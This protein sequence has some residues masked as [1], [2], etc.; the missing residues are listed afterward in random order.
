MAVNRK[1]IEEKVIDIIAEQLSRE[2]D[3]IKLSSD[4]TNDL[5]A[6]SLDLAELMIG[7]EEGFDIDIA[8]DKVG[9]IS[10]VNDVVDQICKAL[11][12]NE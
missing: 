1:E 8:E 5:G 2:K 11:E 3:Q 7:F 12:G 10:T 9:D 6:D 4:I